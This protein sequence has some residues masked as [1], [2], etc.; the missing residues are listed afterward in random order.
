MII[1]PDDVLL[2]ENSNLSGALNVVIH[3][4]SL[5]KDQMDEMKDLQIKYAVR[6]GK[7]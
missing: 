6:I 5:Y 4:N 1:T 7:T 3:D 2:K